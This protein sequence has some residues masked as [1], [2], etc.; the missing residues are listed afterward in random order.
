MRFFSRGVNGTPFWIC[1]S[2]DGHMVATIS[3]Q[4]P[5]QPP[6]AAN[7]GIISGALLSGGGRGVGPLKPNHLII[8][9]LFVDIH[10]HVYMTMYTWPCIHV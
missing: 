6:L 1:R 3:T 10:G 7:T 5:D 8:S 9:N 2:L 4:T